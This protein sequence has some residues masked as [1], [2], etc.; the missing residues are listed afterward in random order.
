[1]VSQTYIL[2]GQEGLIT[3]DLSGLPETCP[4]ATAQRPNVEGDDPAYE[5]QGNFVVRDR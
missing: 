5:V 2:P 4:D 1:V 3:A